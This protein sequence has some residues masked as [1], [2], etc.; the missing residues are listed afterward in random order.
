[1]P[2]WG[3][4]DWIDSL[5]LTV[6]SPWKPW[7]SEHLD[8]SAKQRAGYVKTYAHNFTFA[9]VQGAGHLVSARCPWP[10]SLCPMALASLGLG[11]T[12]HPAVT[13]PTQVPT[14]KPHFALTM[15]SKWLAGEPLA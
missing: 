6:V 4:I 3:T 13:L 11:T 10:C 14:Y 1:M 7:G 5:D 8:G 15:I 2:T 12:P 9:T